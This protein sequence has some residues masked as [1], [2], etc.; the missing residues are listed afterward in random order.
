MGVPEVVPVRVV[1]VRLAAAEGDDN[2]DSSK[3][4]NIGMDMGND[5][6]QADGIG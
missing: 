6:V 5:M 4:S 3:G 1:P 2:K